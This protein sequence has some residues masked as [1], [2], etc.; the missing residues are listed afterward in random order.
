MRGS[1]KLFSVRGI[2][3]KV[4]PTFFLLLLFF[5]VMFGSEGGGIVGA[6][7]GMVFVCLIF[8]CIILHEMSHSLTAQH[9]G[10][11]VRDITLWPIGGIASMKNLPRKPSQELK[12]ALAGP[13]V[14]L[15]VAIL[16]FFIKDKM[17]LS[18]PLFHGTEVDLLTAVIRTNV[19]IAFFN[20]TPA[21]PMDGGRILRA[22]LA[23][24]MDYRKATKIAVTLGQMFALLFFAA[25]LLVRPP[26]P[27]LALIGIFIYFA[28]SQ[29]EM[30]V[31]MKGKGLLALT[32]LLF[33]TGCATT[34]NPVTETEERII[35][36][37]EK[38]IAIGRAV[39]KRIEKK[40]KL[41]EEKAQYVE[42]I[43]RKV[44]FASDRIALPYTFKVIDSDE[45]NAFALP[46]AQFMLPGR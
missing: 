34:Y 2:D 43:G 39:A 23:Q 44:A 41:C 10:V 45:L 31:D 4:H 15:I 1:L 20:L 38:E 25:G 7:W 26:N 35:Y 16:L 22:L 13:P 24:N 46:G 21:L 17:H 30:L 6:I 9:F 14:N 8:L 12:I 5:G 37:R 18:S 29:E 3:V 19:F 11:E 27:F 40:Y 32:L 36:S 33:L 28:A 42:W